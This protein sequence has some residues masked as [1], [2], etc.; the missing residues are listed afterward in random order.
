MKMKTLILAAML[1]SLLSC[2]KD[3]RNNVVVTPAAQAEKLLELPASARANYQIYQVNPKLYGNS[4]QLKAVQA[5][6]DDIKAL[7]T[8]I[9]YLM[10]IYPEGQKN[11]I[12]SPY[13]IKDYTGV[14]DACGTLADVKALVQAAHNKG[15]KVMFDWVANHTAWDHPWIS[16]HSDWYQKD[17]NGNI[18]YPTKD[19]EWKDVAQLDFS[20]SD[21]HNAMIAAMKYWITEAD[22]DGYRCDY[23]HGVPD[24]FWK[25][26]IP[27]LKAVKT[28]FIMLAESDFERMFDDGFDIIY[29]RGLKRAAKTLISGGKLS[30]FAN[31]YKSTLDKT[32]AGKT[33]CYFVTNHDDASENSPVSEFKSKEGAC[34][35]YALLAALNG[36]PMFYGSQE[37]G[38][39]NK[40][41]FFNVVS[42]NW[43]AEPELANRYKTVL[44]ALQKLSRDSACT[45]YALDRVIFVC[46]EG[47]ATIGINLGN[48]STKATLPDGKTQYE[49]GAYE[50]KIWK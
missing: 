29:D 19:G 34:A 20:S 18:V 23:A 3:D 1:A 31:S 15:M 40:I 11:G 43:N 7:G 13:C 22:I 10:P 27:Q 36:S 42:V 6:L 41:N 37:A 14:R 45:L 33:K 28:G 49:F 48:G 38:Y 30:D 2:G 12:G 47:S 8:D 32:P 25:K 5:R 46:Y 17:G 4:G 26:A 39:S 50:A 16:E 9:L 24:A 44:S 21:L 35:A